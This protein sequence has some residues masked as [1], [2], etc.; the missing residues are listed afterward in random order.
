MAFS[1]FVVSLLICRAVV[2]V[3]GIPVS[4]FFCFVSSRSNGVRFGSV[5]VPLL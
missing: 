5:L 1:F 3:T 2:A 4:S